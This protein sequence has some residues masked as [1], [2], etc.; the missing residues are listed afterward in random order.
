MGSTRGGNRRLWRRPRCSGSGVSVRWGVRQ[1]ARPG[2]GR[3]VWHDA[4]TGTGNRVRLR[5]AGSGPGARN[6]WV[7]PGDL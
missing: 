6:R 2:Y 1:G 5:D 3:A 4:G 7:E